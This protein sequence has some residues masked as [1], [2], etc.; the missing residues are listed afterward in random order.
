[1]EVPFISNA[2][3]VGFC[4]FGLGGRGALVPD[5]PGDPVYDFLN[6]SGPTATCGFATVAMLPAD[7]DPAVAVSCMISFI[8]IIIS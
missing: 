2:L 8:F 7:V 5:T 6:L 1:M 3:S 4:F